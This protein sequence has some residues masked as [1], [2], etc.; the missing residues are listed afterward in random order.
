MVPT[1]QVLDEEDARSRFFEILRGEKCQLP[2]WLNIT[3]GKSTVNEI[4]SALGGLRSVLNT[5][6]MLSPQDGYIDFN[7]TK[8]GIDISVQTNYFLSTESNIVEAISANTIASRDLGNGNIEDVYNSEVYR[9]ILQAYLPQTLLL[10]QG[11]PTQILINIEINVAEPSSP[12]YFHIWFLYPEDGIV[13]LYSGYA[14]ITDTAIHVCPSRSFVSLWL[15]SAE[16]R[17]LYMKTLLDISGLKKIAPSP[18]FY[19]STLEAFGMTPNEFL[20]AAKDSSEPCFETL[21]DIWTIR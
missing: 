14:D 15:V 8:A 20:N 5:S 3:P 10:R 2:C 17:E 12:D 18:P 16:D 6:D 11:E 7:Y 1:V 19:K 13:A 9:E 4:Y 21:M